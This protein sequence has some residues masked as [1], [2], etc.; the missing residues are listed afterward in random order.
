[1]AAGWKA[2]AGRLV[3]KGV[4]E[5]SEGSYKRHWKKWVRFLE[6]VPEEERPDR[7][8][9]ELE[10][11]EDKVMCL[12]GF[13]GY[14]IEELNVKGA[15]E[16]GMVLSGVRFGWNREGVESSFFEDSRLHAVKQGARL[17]TGEMRE[18]VERAGERKKIPA[19]NDMIV[20]LRNKYYVES[21]NSSS[22]MYSKG[23]YLSAAVA[24]DMGMRPG[25]V[26]KVDGPKKTDHCIQAQDLLFR[27]ER[28]G[29][30]WGLRGGEP[31]REY[32][33]QS[34]VRG[35][36]TV[37]LERLAEVRGVGIRVVTSKTRNGVRAPVQ[38]WE[39][40]RGNDQEETLLRDLC[41]FM[42]DS[43]VKGTDPF[44]TRYG[45]D[46]KGVWKGK[47]VTAKDLSRAVKEA[48]EAFELPGKHFS[49]K[50]LRSGYATH[51]EKCEVSREK[52]L[53]RGGWSTKSQVP[54]KHY[55]H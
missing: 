16:V 26:R 14:L 41:T 2:R 45:P 23:V 53:R 20:W 39:I 29:K 27:M 38:T 22:G 47:S 55:I 8:L 7:Y 43:G 50:S 28:E 19:S 44:C 32:V 40:G 35:Y 54:Q 34:T 46:S 6:T 36:W 51:M 11:R 24:F 5:G 4:T 15:K 31:I 52:Y 9:V 25:N 42:V 49:G 37:N 17:S 30:A 33:G 3:A 1:M 10:S 18:H 13:I 48:A 12:A 21:D